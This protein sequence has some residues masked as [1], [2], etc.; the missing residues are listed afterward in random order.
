MRTSKPAVDNNQPRSARPF[1]QRARE[2]RATPRDS[3]PL[4]IINPRLTY[5]LEAFKR[6]LGIKNSTL[7]AA[8]RGG[9]YVY[10]VHGRGF[11]MGDDWIQY[12]RSSAGPAKE[13]GTSHA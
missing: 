10:R 11:I 5:T 3:A 12:L 13:K 4:G 2:D 6:L 7:R 8:R 9:L 1:E